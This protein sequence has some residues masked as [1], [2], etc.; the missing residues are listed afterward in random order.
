MQ[1]QECNLHNKRHLYEGL[2]TL[3]ECSANNLPAQLEKLYHPQAQWRGAHPINEHQG[4]HSIAQSVWRPLMHSFPDLERRDLIVIGGQFEKRDYVATLGHYCG[5]FREPWLTIPPSGRPITI[6]YG[7]IHQIKQGRI[8]QSNCLWDILDVMRQV[9]FWPLPPSLGSEGMWQGPVHGDGIILEPTDRAL[10]AANLAQTLAMHQSLGAYDDKAPSPRQGLMEMP[11][12]D[13]WH[14]KMMWYG[15]AGIGT[16]RGLQG[17]V[18]YHQLPFRK[19]FQRP[20]GTLE[21]VHAMRRA[22]GA[23]HY[24][25]IGDGAYSVTA[26]WP[27]LY[28]VHAGDGFLG[29]AATGRMITMRVMD[30]YLHDEGLIR[31]NWVPI[32]LLDFLA[33]I[34]VDVFARMACFFN[35]N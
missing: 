1:L 15:P 20:V 34:G 30:F 27:S 24:I 11:Q 7:E 32:D 21:E 19:A 10:S 29:L 23:G 12:K 4:I 33:Q 28:G 26:G 18:D 6:R 14:P 3:T 22:H 31:E 9:G 8:I 16:T 35:M 2:R 25:R 5:T 17:F 13:Y